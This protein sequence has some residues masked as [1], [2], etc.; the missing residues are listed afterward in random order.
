MAEMGRLNTRFTTPGECIKKISRR[1]RVTIYVRQG[2]SSKTGSGKGERPS[3]LIY[4]LTIVRFFKKL[5][6]T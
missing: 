4:H 3:K 1:W 2:R 6:T 5:D